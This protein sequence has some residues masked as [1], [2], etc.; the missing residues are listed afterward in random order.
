M[1]VIS[2]KGQTYCFTKTDDTETSTM[3]RE[4]CWWIVKNIHNGNFDIK[5]LISLSYVWIS[6]KYY[7]ASYDDETIDLMKTFDDVYIKNK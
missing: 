4:R 5:K 3:F 7:N 2:H 6:M 1:L